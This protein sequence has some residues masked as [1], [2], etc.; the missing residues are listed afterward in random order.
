MMQRFVS[1]SG[2]TAIVAGSGR[3]C[4]RTTRLPRVSQNSRHFDQTDIAIGRAQAQHPMGAMLGGAKSAANRCHRPDARNEA[5]SSF[6]S[7]S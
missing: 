5:G 6:L 2:R 4:P 7:S 1:F 3:T